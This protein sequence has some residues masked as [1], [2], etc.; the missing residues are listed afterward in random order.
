MRKAI[1]AVILFVWPLLGR[2]AE[3]AQ[4]AKPEGLPAAATD[5]FSIGPFP[6][7]SSML[8]TWIVALGV[9]VFARYATRNMKE[10]PDG[11]QN[12]WELLVESLHNFLE[13]VLGPELVKKTFWLFATIFIFILFTNWFGLYSRAWAPSDGARHRARI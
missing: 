13:G 10:V 3:A 9:I 5:V 8:V 7:T 11:A 1:I 4:E 2:A 12:F 6:V